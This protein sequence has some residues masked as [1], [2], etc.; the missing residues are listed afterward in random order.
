MTSNRTEIAG[1]VAG[2]MFARHLHHPASGRM[3]PRNEANLELAPV[4]LGA[5]CVCKLPSLV[6]VAGQESLARL[7]GLRL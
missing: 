4:L 1:Q 6:V 5:D 2:Q 7:L 3:A